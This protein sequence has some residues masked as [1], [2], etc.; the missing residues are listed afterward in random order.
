MFG[1]YTRYREAK[2]LKGLK[3]KLITDKN[4]KSLFKMVTY[5]ERAPLT[6]TLDK[7]LRGLRKVFN[8]RDG[9]DLLSKLEYIRTTLETREDLRTTHL[10]MEHTLDDW[11]SDSANR[12]LKLKEY[13]VELVKRLQRIEDLLDD[14]ESDDRTDLEYYLNKISP[15]LQDTLTL[16]TCLVKL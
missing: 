2:V 7:D 4:Y 9:L 11:L 10:K 8:A 5:L 6:Q 13:V 15:F 14:I 3:G 12:P 16:T 1:W